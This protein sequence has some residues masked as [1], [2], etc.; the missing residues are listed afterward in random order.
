LKHRAAGPGAGCPAR[1]EVGF[2]PEPTTREP[3]SGEPPAA[4]FPS[5]TT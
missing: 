5:G 4:S 2:V 1:L 3:G